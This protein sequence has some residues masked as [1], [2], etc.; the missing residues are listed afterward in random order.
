MYPL[1]M[2]TVGDV[3]GILRVS[4]QTVRTW[5]G[6]FST[7]L[8]PQA[9]PPKGQARTFSPEDVSVLAL[10][11]TMRENLAPYEAIHAALA[12]GE[13]MEPLSSQNEAH[14]APSGATDS[15]PGQT[16]ATM[17]LELVK[18]QVE[19][20]QNERDYLRDQLSAEREARITAEKE[21]ARLAGK[22]EAL[23]SAQPKEP[24]GEG[25]QARPGWWAR[26][27]GRG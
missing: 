15:Q 13:R 5:V 20:L 2:A 8:S 23:E 18:G 21:A 24:T 4:P 12:S 11:A 26:L 1:V 17:A 27:R 3:A 16:A 25:G 19:S 7:Y 9:T 14:E 10:V 6:E 22:L